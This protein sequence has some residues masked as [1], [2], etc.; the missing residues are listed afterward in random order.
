MSPDF[1]EVMAARRRVRI[2]DGAGHW[3]LMRDL[4]N[5]EIWTESYHTPTW[6]EYVRHNQRRTQA[7][8]AI[9]DRIRALHRGLSEPRVH[10]MIERQTILPHDIAAHKTP[11]DLS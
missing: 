4:E 5:P 11:I 9:G 8:A 10:R 1:L 2:R 6:V 3:A 7:D